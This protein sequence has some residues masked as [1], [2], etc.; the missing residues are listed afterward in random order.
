MIIHKN[1]KYIREKYGLSQQE[2]GEIAGVTDKAVSTW[3]LGLKTP[4]MG[5]I[6]KIS[7]HFG[8]PKSKIID[9]DLSNQLTEK[10]T[11]V[12]SKIDQNS[13]IFGER[14]Q[15]LRKKT[16]LTLKQFGAL[17]E[18]G[19][20]TISLYENGKRKPDF[21]TLI[22]M[23]DYFNCSTDYILGRPENAESTDKQKQLS[24]KEKK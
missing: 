3:E 5:S 11:T 19:E 16:G 21:D 7:N 2:F 22:K 8:I 13:L 4:R 15:T 14:L 10:N 24:D 18:L 20:S 1:L 12:P 23:A 6:E 17:F 9:D